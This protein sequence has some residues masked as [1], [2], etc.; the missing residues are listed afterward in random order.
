MKKISEALGAKKELTEDEAVKLINDLKKT[1]EARADALTKK[2]KEMQDALVQRDN[3]AAKALEEK[4]TVHKKEVAEL[5]G[6]ISQVLE[7]AKASKSEKVKTMDAKELDKKADA[8]F[9]S[10]PKYQKIW[11]TSDGT[12]FV[13]ENDAI[14][15]ANK[16]GLSVKAH[17]K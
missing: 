9:K 4:D 1:S 2:A 3:A 7:A 6:K 11:I 8:V 14:E 13:Q 17:T 15:H 5:N 16:N 10:F 12:P